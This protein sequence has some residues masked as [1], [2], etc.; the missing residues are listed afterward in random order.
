MGPIQSGDEPWTSWMIEVQRDGGEFSVSQVFA[1]LKKHSPQARPGLQ[2]MNRLQDMG[3]PEARSMLKL[4]SGK[5][6]V[7][8]PDKEQPDVWELKTTPHPWRFY[9]HVDEL[10]RYI[11]YAHAT[12]KQRTEANPGHVSS[13]RQLL[14]KL[15]DGAARRRRFTFPG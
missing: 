12:Y 3:W 2:K 15:N 13:A 1:L 6:A 7:V 10:K 9:F 11:T 8:R 14:I 4:A 5:N